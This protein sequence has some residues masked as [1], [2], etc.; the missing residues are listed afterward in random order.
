MI[1]GKQRSIGAGAKY[2]TSEVRPAR[3][4]QEHR[5]LFGRDEDL[6]ITVE[7]VIRQQGTIDFTKPNWRRPDP[8]SAERDQGN[9][10]DHRGVRRNRRRQRRQAAAADQRDMDRQPRHLVGMVAS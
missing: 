6:Q 1:E 7:L 5:N 9:P 8:G 2:Y 3:C 4:S 10:A